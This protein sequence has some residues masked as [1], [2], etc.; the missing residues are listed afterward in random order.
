MAQMN[1]MT[2]FKI[3]GQAI[4]KEMISI[5]HQKLKIPQSRKQLKESH[6]SGHIDVI[7]SYRDKDG[8]KV[9]LEQDRET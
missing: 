8:M 7:H 6:F 2:L 5:K 9:S 1:S 4:I 3:I